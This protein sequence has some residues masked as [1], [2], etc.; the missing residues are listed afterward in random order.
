M[1]NKLVAVSMLATAS[2]L[3]HDIDKEYKGILSLLSEFSG[4]VSKIDQATVNV[5][6]VNK[7]SMWR[8]HAIEERDQAAMKET[9]RKGESELNKVKATVDRIAKKRLGKQ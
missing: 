5:E 7:N 4:S 9:A 3:Q 2:A 8:L 1:V 6:E